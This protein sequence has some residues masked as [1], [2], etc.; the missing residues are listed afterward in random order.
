MCWILLLVV[1]K[2]IVSI[3]QHA[4]I[5]RF[6][7]HKYLNT[8]KTSE[9]HPCTSNKSV[10]RWV[11]EI[12]IDNEPIKRLLINDCSNFK[13][14]ETTLPTF[15]IYILL[16]PSKNLRQNIKE[17]HT[18]DFLLWQSTRLYL[19]FSINHM[20]ALWV[21]ANVLLSIHRDVSWNVI[22]FV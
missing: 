8:R 10:T 2:L 16:D 17:K 21:F 12:F 1:I 11:S 9:S 4:A 19:Y 6:A 13:K 22:N 18:D 3:L 14:T 5:R 15:S 7:V 20:S